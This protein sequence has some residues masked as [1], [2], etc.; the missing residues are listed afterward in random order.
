M[1]VLRHP[2]GRKIMLSDERKA[3]EKMVFVPGVWPVRTIPKPP[4]H[5]NDPH[6]I[7]EVVY[8]G[9]PPRKAF[10]KASGKTSPKGP[11]KTVATSRADA[12]IFLRNP[13]PPRR[14]APVP[15]PSSSG[16]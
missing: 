11:T 7:Q 13:R 9:A 14:L 3:R 4:G 16:R 10:P 5:E 12:P 8:I 2:D 15:R 6:Y 1:E